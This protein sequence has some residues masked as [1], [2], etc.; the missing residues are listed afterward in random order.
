MIF[1]IAWRNLWRHRTRTLIMTS[2]VALTYALMLV[3]L[4]VSDDGHD[5]MLQEAA[6]AAGG[7]ILVDGKGYWNTRASDIVIPDGEAV[8]QEVRGVS[9][10]QDVMPRV[11]INGLVSTSMDNRP[12]LLQGIRPE[13]ETQLDKVKRDTRE[14]TFLTGD[15]RDPIVLGK[16]LVDRLGL[17]LGDRVVLTATGPDGELTR[18]LFHLSGVF[19]TGTR[20]VDEMMG[21]TTLAAA[22]KAVGMNGA[23]TQ[24]GVRADHDA[25]VDS[26]AAHIRAAVNPSADSLEVLTWRDAVPEMVGFVQIDNAFGYIYIIV[27]FGVVMFSITNTFLMAV[28]ERV[29]E[30]GLLNAL[31]LRNIR[32]GRLLLTETVLMTLIAMAVGFLIGYGGHLII[33]HFGISMASYGLDEI[34]VSGVDMSD[35]VMYSTIVPIKWIIASILVA[36]ATIG[37]AV[38]PAWRASRLAPA[39]AMRF[40]E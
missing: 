5:R 29:R 35:L 7:D 39:E 31:G 12:L 8:V 40:F 28:M 21:Y 37:S 17:K 15:E 27:I 32:I 25:N 24:I 20:E 23:L 2:A 6:R 11:I 10:V 26:V 18:A 38:Y 1:K 36:V 13:L 16:R 33:K 30:F 4:G 19:Q 22:G 14:G 34:D 3:S 9:G